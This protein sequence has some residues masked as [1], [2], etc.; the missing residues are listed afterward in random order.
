MSLAGRLR[1]ALELV[2]LSGRLIGGRR[3]W[4]A[5]LLP[6]LW[7]AFQAIRLLL[8][9]RQEIFDPVSA[10]NTLVGLPLVVL[11]IGL[12]VRVIAGEVD[13]R[14]LEIAYTVPGGCQRVWLAKLAAAV[15]LLVVA[16]ALLAGVA[17]AFFTAVPAGALYGALQAAVLFLV[18]AMAMG[19]LFANEVTGAMGTVVVLLLVGMLGGSSRLSPFFNPLAVEQVDPG[20]V[21]AWTVQNRVGTALAIAAVS[22][23]AFARA[24]R[25]EKLLGGG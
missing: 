12:G 2:V 9:W 13:R 11:A 1:D 17:F 4:L 18:V 6:L 3:F 10:Q 8:G 15:G 23:L 24:E 5:P 22:A 21:L 20:V 25:R 16:E 7:P 19:A 14:T